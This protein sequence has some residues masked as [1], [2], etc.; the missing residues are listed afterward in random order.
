M[1]ALLNIGVL[2]D[3]TVV[4]PTT[5]KL[6]LLRFSKRWLAWDSARKNFAICIVKKKVNAAL[7]GAVLKQHRRFHGANP[8]AQ[9]FAANCPDPVGIL[10]PVGFIKALTYTV[11]RVITSPGKQDHK[12]RKT[13]DWDHKFGDT[14][15]KGGKYPESVMPL[16][17][18]D[19]R[20]NYFFKRRKGN[21]FNV[22]EW[23]RG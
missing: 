9:P 22:D 23:L 10:E 19:S 5:G 16:L 17:L 2:K 6:G 4:H 13:I 1:K 21:I 20:G 15:H 11:P 12:T 7:P 8:T 14:G 3:I 18:R